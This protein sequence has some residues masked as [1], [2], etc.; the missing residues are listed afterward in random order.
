VRW[1]GVRRVMT[2]FADRLRAFPIRI[3]AGALAD[4]IPRRDLL[5]SPDHA[6]LLD[7]ILVQAGALVNGTSITQEASMPDRFTYYH[8]EVA[9][10][11]LILAENAATES[12]IDNAGRMNFDNWGEYE[13]IY[14]NAPPIAELPHPRAKSV[15]QVPISLRYWLTTRAQFFAAISQR[16]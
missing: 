6:M 5:V 13:A 7:G 9:E 3:R 16:A 4:G 1:V 10:H 12:F 11:A 15:R 8:V 14:A 2:R